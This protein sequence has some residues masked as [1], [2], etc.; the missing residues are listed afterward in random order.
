MNEARNIVAE[1][2]GLVKE[3]VAIDSIKAATD[4]EAET[5]K[6]NATGSTLGK[7][8]TKVIKKV[9]NAVQNLKNKKQSKRNGEIASADKPGSSTYSSTRKK[10]VLAKP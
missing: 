10:A 2:K 4:A 7:Y 9:D 3:N 5:D 8:A 6:N 1:K